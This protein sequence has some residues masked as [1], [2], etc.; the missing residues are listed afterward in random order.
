[1]KVMSVNAETLNTVG[2]PKN[3]KLG[4][5]SP[6]TSNIMSEINSI[7]KPSMVTKNA[8]GAIKSNVNDTSMPKATALGNK[9]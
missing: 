3:V 2:V 6:D 5:F 7:P 4:T 8:G 9:G 1:M